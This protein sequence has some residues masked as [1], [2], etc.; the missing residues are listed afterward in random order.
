MYV[1]GGILSEIINPLARRRF[2]I[3]HQVPARVLIGRTA[4][5]SETSG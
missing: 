3:Q 4:H 1:G 2:P 5:P